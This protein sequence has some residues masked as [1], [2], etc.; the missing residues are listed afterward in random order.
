MI[1][2]NNLY[3]YRLINQ[4]YIEEIDCTL[5]QLSHDKSGATIVYLDST[6]NNKTFT[7]AFKTLPHDSTGVCHIIEHSTLCGSK[8]YPLKEP[9]VNLLKGSMA[10]FLN[11]MTSTDKTLYPIASLN[12]KDFDNLMSVYLD[13][14]FSPLSISDPKPFLQEGWHLE[15]NNKDDYP[16]YK[17]VVYNEMK[18]AMSSPTRILY[19]ATLESLYKGTGYEYNSGG[20]PDIIPNLTYEDY[21][22]FYETHY[23][24]E[25]SIIVLYGNMNVNEKLKFIEDEYLSKYEKKG[26][27]TKLDI[28][29]PH[30]DLDFIK[31][32]GISKEE[33]TKDNY[34]VSIAFG[35]EHVSNVRD[36]SAINLLLQSLMD[37][38]DSLLKKELMDLNLGSDISFEYN[39]SSTV[40]ALFFVLEKT[41]AGTKEILY[42]EILKHIKK[43]M[44]EGSYKKSLLASIN[45]SEFSVKEKDFGRLPKGL[46]YTFQAVDSYAYDLDI[47]KSF[48]SIKDFEFYKNNIDSGYFEKLVD[49]YILNNEY[50]SR[51]ELV[52]ST[53][54]NSVKKTEMDD[55]MKDIKSKM[56]DKE[57][58]D[59]INLNKELFEYQSKEDTIEELKTLPTLKKED[60]TVD[61]DTIDTKELNTKKYKV[62]THD[63]NTNGISYLKMY[64]DLSILNKEELQTVTFYS[65]LLGNLDTKD[66]KVLDLQ[67]YVLT[68]L[69]L[70]STSVIV[71]TDFN[72]NSIPMLVVSVSALDENIYYI[73]KLLDN[74][75]FTSILDKDKIKVILSQSII[76][77]KQSIMRNGNT[78]AV[79]CAKAKVSKASVLNT[80]ID[81]PDLYEFYSKSSENIDDLIETL[82][83][84]RYKIF[85]YNNLLVSVSGKTKELLDI[86]D[87]IEL[88]D[89]KY[90]NKLKYDLRRKED[91]AILI[92]SGVSYNAIAFN[93]SQLGYKF[94]GS[95]FVLNHIIRNDYLW[96]KVR[97]KGGA[98]GTSISSS[99]SDDCVSVSS[100][101]DPNV[102]NTY[103]AFYGI[104]EYLEKFNPSDEEFITYIIGSASG[105]NKPGSINSEIKRA[106]DLYISKTPMEFRIK[107]VEEL[108]NTTVDDI[109]KFSK[110]FEKL[111]E[112]GR[113][114]SIGNEDKINEYMPNALKSR[115]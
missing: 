57:V 82:E 29:T 85:G 12:D 11:A 36:N 70:A 19:Q 83:N 106:D 2:L 46:I 24:P 54:F 67:N 22:E 63:V 59:L 115:L 68:Y 96:N 20:D 76:G 94:N 33:S 49:K 91:E 53:L 74:M 80:M 93:Y 8:K 43:I 111:E 109:R 69:G 107:T 79:A 101:R 32:Y 13:A 90:E 95:F 14:V 45:H 104:K 87:S 99:Y 27:S 58:D 1:D 97:V 77:L 26:L 71:Y 56:S 81:G 16:I 21:K 112:V 35:L 41:N 5:Y 89:T 17:G 10:T 44:D 50:V 113:R 52:P 37:S 40:P 42:K 103:N 84:V 34:Y 48:E 110:L 64:F 75:L 55:L 88:N 39:D 4:K 30:K 15:L 47:I 51:V 60:I 105:L 9:F 98:Y 66:F 6:D 73:K 62:I 7:I 38:N 23:I 72:K 86:V 114:F 61:L 65:D 3:G 108:I 18:G 28:P 25:N 31:E 102:L 100:Y 78:Y 92:E